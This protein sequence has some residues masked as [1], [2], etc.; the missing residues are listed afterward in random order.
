MIGDVKAHDQEGGGAVQLFWFACGC[1]LQL[2][3]D[4]HGFEPIWFRACARHRDRL[5]I[6]DAADDCPFLMCTYPGTHA[7]PVCETC[8]ASRYG[9]LLCGTCQLRRGDAVNPIILV[10]FT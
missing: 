3:E 8:G 5:G 9:N 4:D 10:E 7:H 1:E 6:A 2:E